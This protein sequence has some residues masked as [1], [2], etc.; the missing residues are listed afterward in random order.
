M[1]FPVWLKDDYRRFIQVP[2]H[3]ERWRK[4]YN[5]RTS[6]ERVF[7][8]LKKDGDGKLVDHRIRGL[9]KVT[10]NCLLSVWVMQVKILGSPSLRSFTS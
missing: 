2:R 6:V 7:S 9:E 3:T 4:L 8:R 1:E 10:L 5:M